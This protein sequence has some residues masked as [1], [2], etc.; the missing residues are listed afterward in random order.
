M[1]AGNVN[2]RQNAQVAVGVANGVR[3]RALQRVLLFNRYGAQWQ[4]DG[5]ALAT[6]RTKHINTAAG[7]CHGAEDVAAVTVVT[8]PGA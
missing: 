4:R 1:L 8:D 7:A 5:S 6:R 2:V 3:Q